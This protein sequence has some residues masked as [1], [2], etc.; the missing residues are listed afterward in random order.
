MKSFKKLFQEAWLGSV[1]TA[2]KPKPTKIIKPSDHKIGGVKSEPEKKPSLKDIAKQRYA[3][4]PTKTPTMKTGS[5]G[6]PTKEIPVGKTPPIKKPEVMKTSCPFMIGATDTPYQ[7]T[8][9]PSDKQQTLAV[10]PA[11][12]GRSSFILYAG[13]SKKEA[14][15]EFPIKKDYS[16][17]VLRPTMIEV[18]K[19]V[20]KVGTKKRIPKTKQVYYEWVG[21]VPCVPQVLDGEPR[22]IGLMMLAMGVDNPSFEDYTLYMWVTKKGTKFNFN[23][24]LNLLKPD[25]GKEPPHP[26]LK[27][28]TILYSMWGYEQTN[29]EFYVVIRSNATT[30]YYNEL[31]SEFKRATGPDSATKVP[32][33]PTAKDML[34]NSK[35]F[36]KRINDRGAKDPSVTHNS[37]VTLDI[38]DGEEVHYSWGH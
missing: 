19:T 17:D 24:I 21:D 32:V 27:P 31:K 34:P 3:G 13:H 29:V 23:K 6:K 35:T 1:T 28:G 37:V 11:A 9:I 22:S 15:Q 36:K 4:E 7:T 26:K 20:L 8:L 30:V 12:Y 33:K 38:W 18:A 10:Q 16:N 5:V 2:A 25:S 14:I